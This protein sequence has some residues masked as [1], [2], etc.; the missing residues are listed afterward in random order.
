[1]A[2]GRSIW[3]HKSKPF[4]HHVFKRVALFG[5][6]GSLWGG[7][8]GQWQGIEGELSCS[9]GAEPKAPCPQLEELKT[10]PA[11]LALN[12]ELSGQVVEG[13]LEKSPSPWALL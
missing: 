4:P 10:M 11:L 9:V 2:F 12:I 3:N 7:R 5:C 6:G 13:P 8:S 1:M